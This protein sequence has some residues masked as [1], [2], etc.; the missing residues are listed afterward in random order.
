MTAAKKRDLFEEI[1]EGLEAYRHRCDTLSR[2]KLFP[3]EA[4]AICEQSG[5]SQS[6]MAKSLN[7][8]K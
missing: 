4:K 2:R 1:R 7:V 6:H 5:M 3:P 8:S